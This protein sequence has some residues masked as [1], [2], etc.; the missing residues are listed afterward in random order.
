MKDA[1]FCR[2]VLIDCERR[3]SRINQELNTVAINEAIDKVVAVLSGIE[4]E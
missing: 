4:L 2:Y 1:D 3:R